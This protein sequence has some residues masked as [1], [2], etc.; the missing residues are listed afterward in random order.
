[1]SFEEFHSVLKPKVD[2]SWNLH[3]QLPSGMDFFVLL[4]SVAGVIGTYGQSNYAAGN[5]YQD[6]LA[7]HRISNGEKAIS[8]DLGSIKDVGY[9]AEKGMVEIVDSLSL[10]SIS[11]KEF[12]AIIEHACNPNLP[13]QPPA[14]CQIIT[15]IDPPS[16]LEERGVEEPYWMQ[17]PLFKP[18]Y[19]MTSPL[20]HSKSS[21][22][23]TATNYRE[24]IAAAESLQ[25]VTD[26]IIVGLQHKLSATL[27]VEIENIDT[28]RPMHTYGVDSLSAV[29]VRT[30]FRNAVGV[31]IDVFE[32]LGNSSIA[33][34]AGRVASTSLFVGIAV[35]G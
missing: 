15:G 4:S 31:D 24:L 9:I 33:Q 7:A 25:D 13:V 34:L 10:T 18:L 17:G 1:M 27:G 26:I 30:W 11:E 23:D 28:S 5:T 32:I 3:S 6:A 16:V 29:E 2:G 19:Q 12:L 35:K 21:T 22:T 20:V 8:I 14:S